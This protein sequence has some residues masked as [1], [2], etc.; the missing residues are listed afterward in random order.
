[1]SE[2]PDIR[3]GRQTIRVSN[4]DRIMFPDVGV[5]KGE[6]VEYYRAVAPAML[7]HL[8]GRP[9]SMERL[10][11]GIGGEVF[12]QKQISSHYPPW[13]DRVT[14]PKEGGEVTHVVCNKAA[15]LVYIANQ[16]CVTPHVWLSRAD[17]LA[18]PDRLI[19]D[20]DPGSGG[21]A[22]A[23][24]A[25]RLAR[26][27]FADLG[28]ASFLMATGSR[29]FHVV[30]PIRGTM[31]FEQVGM[32]AQRLAEEI[33]RRQ[34]DRLT[35]EFR[36]ADRKGRLFVDYLRNSWAQTAVPPYAV[37][38]RPGATVAVPLAWDELEDA[39]PGGWNVRTIL[40]RLD[41]N[42]DPWPG[43]TRSARSLS[44]AS[45]RLERLS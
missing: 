24:L 42:I 35:T 16:N 31:R 12:F 8:R 34:P 44:R 25:A 26:E 18:R 27:V 4:A 3:V 11:R 30:A 15:T 41:T 6:I 33:A 2:T 17:D 14:L 32:I 10:P 1:V 13:I 45:R 9:I 29:G 40:D 43:F 7:P 38:I 20:M 19:L 28:L 21:T 23:R 37:R 39:D 36:K 5:T 22:D